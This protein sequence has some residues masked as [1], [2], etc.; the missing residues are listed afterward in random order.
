MRG[1]RLW[2]WL[3]PLRVTQQYGLAFIAAH[4]SSTGISHHNLLS[5]I[6]LVSLSSQQQPSPW[7]YSTIPKLQLPATAL[8]RVCMA[9]A[10]TVRFS[11]HL[12]CHRS[13]ISLS[14]L[15]VSPLIQTV[16]PM[17]GLGPPRAGALLTL[18][19]PPLVPSSY[20]VLPGS[21]YS[22]LLVRY[23]CLLSAGVLHALLCLKAYS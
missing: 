7:D 10:R 13:A 8:S 4:L 21:I 2:G 23:S 22:F 15:N 20:R 18:P 16:A 17:W 5:H 19:F 11:F 1:E 3:H 14:A 9:T 6:P 12:G